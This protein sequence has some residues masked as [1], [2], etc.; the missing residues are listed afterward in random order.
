[1]QDSISFQLFLCRE[2]LVVSPDEGA[3]HSS[4]SPTWLC[5]VPCVS[6]LPGHGRG[7]DKETTAPT[8]WSRPSL[9]P[10]HQLRRGGTCTSESSQ[11]L[12]RLPAGVW[13]SSQIAQSCC[14]LI[15]ILLDMIMR[16]VEG[17]YNC[18]VDD[19]L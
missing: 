2:F 10:T 4:I 8:L 19:D 5:K 13:L 14:K 12:C 6:A 7:R 16:S 18:R 11:S 1:M 17:L 15:W 9:L 3:R